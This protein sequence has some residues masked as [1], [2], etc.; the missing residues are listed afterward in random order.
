M[1]GTR[2]GPYEILAKLGQ[3]GMGEVYRA[4]DTQL[5]RQ[6]ALKVLPPEVSGDADRLAR[7]QRESEVLA[8]L[9]QPHIAHIYGVERSGGTLALVME[10][11]EG[12]ESV[13]A[14]RARTHPIRRSVAHRQADRRGARNGARAGNHSPGSQVREHQ[15]AK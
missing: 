2:L 11:V 10:L 12:E 1:I 7:F 15:S 9:N 4:T 14:D 8:A 5:K 13:A 6:V 3:G